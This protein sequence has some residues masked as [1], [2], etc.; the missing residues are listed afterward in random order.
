[1][2]LF[3]QEEGCCLGCLS[4]VLAIFSIWVTLR[5]LHEFWRIAN[6]LEAIAK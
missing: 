1:M 4:V 2:S 3:E 5:F 6:A